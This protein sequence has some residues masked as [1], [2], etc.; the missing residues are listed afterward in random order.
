[1][2]FENAFNRHLSIRNTFNSK[3]FLIFLLLCSLIIYQLF[4]IIYGAFSATKKSADIDVLS[5]L[6]SSDK[7]KIRNVTCIGSELHIEVSLKMK[8]AKFVDF[9]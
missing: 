9:N 5:F 1:M 2:T 6:F 7:T 3:S 4:K 8:Q